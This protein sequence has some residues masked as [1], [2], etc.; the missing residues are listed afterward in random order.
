MAPGVA[1]TGR[2]LPPVTAPV[3]RSPRSPTI[4][5]ARVTRTAAT[6]PVPTQPRSFVASAAKSSVES[7]LG[8]GLKEIGDLLALFRG[9]NGFQQRTPVRADLARGALESPDHGPVQAPR[10]GG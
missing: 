8:S 6:A 5:A 1:D 4:A 3:R 9:S 2:R 7:P 10:P